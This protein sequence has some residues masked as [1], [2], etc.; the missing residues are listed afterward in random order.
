[1]MDGTRGR[2]LSLRSCM[3]EQGVWEV[4]WAGPEGEKEERKINPI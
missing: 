2:R 3:A 1:M 4:G